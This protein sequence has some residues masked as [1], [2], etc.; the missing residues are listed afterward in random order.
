M[1]I[2]TK[3]KEKIADKLAVFLASTYT[4]YLKTLYYHWNV[5]GREFYSLHQLFEEQYKSLAEAGDEIAE[6]IRA[7]GHVAPGTFRRYIELSQLQE[8][9]N[10]P[11]DSTSMVKNLLRDN[12]ICSAKAEEIVSLAQEIGDE[13]TVDLAIGR[14]SYHQDTA[15]KLRS[16]IS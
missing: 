8:D 13:V 3:D 15:W 10:L 4:L 5:V 12:E 1:N 7:L 11:S 9:D 16:M 6:R 2:S 14:M